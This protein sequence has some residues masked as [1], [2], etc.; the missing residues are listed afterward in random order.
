MIKKKE[1]KKGYARLVLLVIYCLRT[2]CNRFKNRW[3]LHAALTSVE[4]VSVNIF[5]M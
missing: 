2:K 1:N 5:G 4:E 3:Q